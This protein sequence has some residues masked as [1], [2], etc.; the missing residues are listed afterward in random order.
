MNELEVAW[1]CKG[2]KKLE[3]FLSCPADE[4]LFG[5]SA[6][7]G[8]TEGLLIAAIGGQGTGLFENPSWRVLI[9]RR[10][11]SQVDI[12]RL[13]TRAKELFNER[14]KYNEVKHRWTFGDKGGVIQFGHI[15]NSSDV[16]LYDGSEFCL[17]EFDELTHFTERM[18]LYLFTRLRTTD[19]RIK[20]KIKSSTTPGGLGHGWVKKRFIDGKKANEIYEEA[21]EL[22]NGDMMKWSKCFIPG[23][24][25]DNKVLMESN[26]GYVRTLM[27]LPEVEKQAKLYGNWEIFSGQFFTEFTDDHICDDFDFPDTWPVWVSMDYG[28]ATKTAIGFYT[29]D[30]ETEDYYRFDEIYTCPQKEGKMP[31]DIGKMIKDRLGSHLSSLIGRFTD[32]R[33]MIRDDRNVSTHEKFCNEGLNFEIITNDRIQGWHRAREALMKGKDGLPRFYVMRKCKEFIRVMPEM[34]FDDNDREDMRHKSN[35]E[36]HI[37]DEFRYWCVARHGKVYDRLEQDYLSYS[38]VTGYPCKSSEEVP[39]RLQISRLT[40]AKRG[41]NYFYH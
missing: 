8:K 1:D 26:P 23:T 37:P 4:I 20:P 29:Q 12:S 38:S 10:T 18:Y 33:L 22:P 32:R 16:Y 34:I 19:M 15:K 25:F 14:G 6:G 13:E 30:I 31:E 9:L 40:G 35:D 36:T 24:V 5:G 7:V 27:E 2:N 41:I 3:L 17:I 28:A 11:F 39:L 21:M